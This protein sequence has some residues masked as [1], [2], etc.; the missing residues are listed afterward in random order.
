VFVSGKPFQ[1]IVKV[2]K[3]ANAYPSEVAF[4][5]STLGKA[6]SLAFKHQKRLERLEGQTF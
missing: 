1:P 6:T 4:R 5:C 3:K 2:A